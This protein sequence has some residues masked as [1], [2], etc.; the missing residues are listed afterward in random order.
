MTRPSFEA[1]GLGGQL[2]GVT[3]AFILWYIIF[4]TQFLGSFWFR[5][6]FATII[7]SIYSIVLSKYI[8]RDFLSKIDYK[9]ILK[10]IISGLLLYILFFIGFGTFKVFVFEGAKN[11][12]FF[13]LDPYFFLSPILLLITSLG[14]EIFWR[15]YIQRALTNKFKNGIIFTSIIYSL[16]HIPTQNFPLIFAALVAGLYWGF[17]YEKTGSLW[18]V[19]SS[20]FIWTELIFVLFPLG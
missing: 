16:I 18:L 13:R 10:G 17:L 12:Y 5:I 6:T 11:V 4:N 1:Q 9:M 15:G 8:V 20:H 3:F 2:I 19:I 7:L 14:E